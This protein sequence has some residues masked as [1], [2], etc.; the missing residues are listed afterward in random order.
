[1]SLVIA[2]LGIMTVLIIALNARYFGELL[3]IMDD[4]KNEGHKSHTLPTPLVGALM[5][6]ALAIFIIVNQYFLGTSSRMVAISVCTILAGIL[7]LVDD[8]LQL[9]WQ[10]RLFTIAAIA[11]I[12]VLWVPELRL[13]SLMWSFGYTTALGPI[14]GGA[15]T[16]ICLMTLIISFNMMDGF[17]GGVIG[18]SLILFV[19]MAI[20]AT[21][22]H[23]QAICLFLA[24]A[25]G[26]M[27]VYNMKGD[28]FLGDGGAYALGLLVGSVAI[29]TYNV[30]ASITVYADTI[31]VWLATPTL[32]CLRVVISRKL[33]KANPF[34]AGRDHLHHMAMAV[35]GQK[36]TLLVYSA[37]ITGFSGLSLFAGQYTYLVFIGE[38][39]ALA[40]VAVTAKK[41][42]MRKLTTAA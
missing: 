21:N 38:V 12:L 32:D 22:A 11:T 34:Y 6:G 41:L 42:K 14:F 1:M 10:V 9:S 25:L 40:A 24:S 35:S 19:I 39:G 29:L 31:F 8:K 30:G 33:T 16:I 27:F 23:R 4:P 3:G 36:R 20:V 28:F 5:I 37:I 18:M 26:V 2:Y 13:D 15:F 7:G 17:N